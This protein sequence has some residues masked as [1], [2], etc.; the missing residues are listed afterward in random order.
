M[1]AYIKLKTLEYPRHMG[2]IMLEHPELD[3]DNFVCPDTYAPVLDGDV[4]VYNS[5]TQTLYEEPPSQIDG[6]WVKS[7]RIYNFTQEEIDQRNAHYEAMKARRRN[8]EEVE[9]PVP[10]EQP[11]QDSEINLERVEL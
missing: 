2:D 6:V 9:E 10:A 4:P 1:S 5:M 7:W 11:T 3:A 8:R